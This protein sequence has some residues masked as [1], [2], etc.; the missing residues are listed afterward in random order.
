MR[1][2]IVQFPGSNCDYDTLHVL[3]DIMELDARLIW[4]RKFKMDSFDAVILPGGFSY[5]DHLRAGIIAASSPAMAEVKE[6]ASDGKPVIG[7]CNGFQILVESGLLPGAL[8]RNSCLRFVCKWVTLRVESERSC[9]TNLLDVGGFVRLPIAH[10]EGRYFADED[11]LKDLFEKRVVLFRY[12]GENPNGSLM[13]IAGISDY[14]GNVVGLMPH[15]ERASE[16]IL[17]SDDGLR[18]FESMREWAKR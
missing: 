8:L 16:S 12:V 4:H 5:G 10:N 15:P 1:V 3:K 13:E 6:F 2:A 7:I 17:G 18:L 9:I 11:T 14:D